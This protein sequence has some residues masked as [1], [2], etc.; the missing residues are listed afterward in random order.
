VL[1]EEATERPGRLSPL[2]QIYGIQATYVCAACYL[3]LFTQRVKISTSGNWMAKLLTQ[4]IEGNMG[5]KQI[6]S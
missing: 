2:G 3:P 6:Q 5:T 4:P 1:F